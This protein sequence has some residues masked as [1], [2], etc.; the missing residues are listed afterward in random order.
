MKR[1][2]SVAMVTA[3]TLLTLLFVAHAQEVGASSIPEKL[4]QEITAMESAFGSVQ[5]FMGELITEVKTNMSDIEAFNAQMKD[6][7]DVVAAVS[8]EIKQAEGKILGL[9][10]DVDALGV[11]YEALRARVD[12]LEG[13]LTELASFC[14]LLKSRLD[15]QEV[16][17]GTLRSEFDALV[18]SFGAHMSDYAG[19]RDQLTTELS[20]MDAAYQS[21]FDAIETGFAASL[22]G[23]RTEV[24]AGMDAL[25]S[26]LYG[27]IDGVRE[28]LSSDITTMESAF[29]S[30]MTLLES[31]YGELMG[32]VRTLEDEDV[33][34]FK[35]KVLELE[36]SMAALAIKVD[37]N[38]ATLEGFD[39]AI[40]SL[41]ADMA[42]TKD[43]IL[44]ANKELLGQY[45]LRLQT[46]EDNAAYMKTQI[47]TLYFISIVALLAGVGAL[48][49][50][51]LGA[52]S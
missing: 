7:K 24:Y 8:V 37:N 9:R 3:L 14:D 35:K 42:T 50:G 38:R 45:D 13:G 30:D 2:L 51:F 32:R 49:W 1:A 28:S 40:A 23:L 41:S 33:G 29:S 6:L 48:I 16:D 12:A 17:L 47:D 5:A 34:T 26:G 10:T 36:R 21:R 19:F 27:E 43:G 11:G 52:S 44:E 25:Q 31:E 22:D 39:Q 20:T 15:V 46:V 18:D 4:E